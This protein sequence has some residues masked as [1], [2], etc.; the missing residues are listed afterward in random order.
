MNHLF[1]IL[2]KLAR[3]CY[4]VDV[5]DFRPSHPLCLVD[6]LSDNQ[7]HCADE[8][9]NQC[10]YQKT[11]PVSRVV[12]LA[13][14]VLRFVPSQCPHLLSMILLYH[15][16][17]IMSSAFHEKDAQIFNTEFVQYFLK[18]SWYIILHLCYN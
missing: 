1:H 3:L 10:A 14:F 4:D 5:R 7:K 13:F 17:A 18:I 15:K 12:W 9:V 16:C 6:Y 2:D 11:C 8:Q